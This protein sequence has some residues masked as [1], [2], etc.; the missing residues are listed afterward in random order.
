MKLIKHVLTLTLFF[1]ALNIN[2]QTVSVVH[3]TP[4]MVCYGTNVYAYADISLLPPGNWRFEWNRMDN[5][6]ASGFTYSLISTMPQITIWE[7]GL[8]VCSVFDDAQGLSFNSWNAVPIL[9]LPNPAIPAG[10]TLLRKP[11]ADISNCGATSV[12][13]CIPDLDINNLPPR[14][15]YKDNVAIP[16]AT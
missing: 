4:T 14:Q 12:H 5:G 2:A 9:V 15:W 16:N 11:Q 3:T 8:Y 10:P 13:L 7:T 1:A 6:C